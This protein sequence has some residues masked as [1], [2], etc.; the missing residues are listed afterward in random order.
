MKKRLSVF[1]SVMLALVM[2][3][4]LVACGNEDGNKPGNKPDDKDKPGQIVIADK[5]QSG[6]ANF[7]NAVGYTGTLKL[8]V[9]NSVGAAVDIDVAVTKNGDYL[10]VV[11]GGADPW[12]IIVNI[13]TGYMY[14]KAGNDYN[15]D[16][17]YP[18]GTLDLVKSVLGSNMQDL[19]DISN[20]EIG[21]DA[22]TK[23]I[24]I[25]CDAKAT[26]NGVLAALSE[27]Y[28]DDTVVVETA[29]N[30]I[31][32]AVN[33]DGFPDVDTVLETITSLITANKEVT[34]GEI[35]TMLKTSYNIDVY[36]SLEEQMGKETVDALKPVLNAR[37]MKEAIVAVYKTLTAPPSGDASGD[38]SGAGMESMMS[39]IVSAALATPVDAATV[40]ADLT[41]AIAYVKGMIDGL[42]A[43]PAQ[44]YIEMLASVQ[45]ELYAL[46]ANNV[47][48]TA[49]SVD[50]SVKFNDD[51]KIESIKFDA[52]CAHNYQVATTE[53]E[54][55]SEGEESSNSFLSAND[56]SI[57]F[58]LAVSEYATTSTPVEIN[59]GEGLP[60]AN[61]II[62]GEIKSDVTVKLEGKNLPA[63]SAEKSYAYMSIQDKSYATDLVTVGDGDVV[64]DPT[65]KT[66]TFKAAYINKVIAAAKTE[67]GTA[68]GMLIMVN[69]LEG[70]ENYYSVQLMYLPEDAQELSKL[71][72]MM[73][74]GSTPDDPEISGPEISG[75]EYEY[76]Y[77]A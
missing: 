57:K 17:A 1:F 66:V 45:P 56:Y 59:V 62:F 61:K 36:A 51:Y 71:I 21:Y 30:N 58:D 5:L 25:A 60:Q 41:A 46:I 32:K 68:D 31:L 2:A 44:E 69:I 4:A 70:E 26:V 43:Q 22:A 48:F 76:G 11:E 72:G 14:T 18:Q 23:T 67:W 34:I 10:T 29:L 50:L 55:G 54:T 27:A 49:L 42:L 63:A 20:D 74:G 28:A 65:A 33:I 9:K 64:Y 47:Q 19:P 6:I 38:G 8:E 7:V 75:G 53:G 52:L 13:E 37:K 73:V 39:V 12:E 3:F 24:K 15:Y 77:A 16:M 40:D 35:I